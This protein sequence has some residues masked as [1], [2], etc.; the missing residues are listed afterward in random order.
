MAIYTI[1]VSTNYELDKKTK[2][3]YF[4]SSR[5]VGYYTNEEYAISAVEA[6]AADIQEHCYNYAI[7]EK[8]GEGLYN[9][10]DSSERKVYAWTNDFGFVRIY[11]YECM[12]HFCGFT[13]G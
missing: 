10:A 4:G 7:I 13:I 9:P 2:M 3:P 6:N 11:D 5:I 12:K 1:M 8:V